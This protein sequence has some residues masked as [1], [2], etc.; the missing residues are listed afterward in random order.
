MPYLVMRGDRGQVYPLS[1]TLVRIGRG[2]DQDIILPHDQSSISRRHAELIHRDGRW[3]LRDLGSRNGTQLAG[4]K[5]EPDVPLPLNDGDIINMGRLEL[6]FVL[7]DGQL[8]GQE[9]EDALVV[10]SLTATLLADQTRRISDVRLLS[11]SDQRLALLMRLG[12]AVG[13][14]PAIPALLKHLLKLV[15]SSLGPERAYIG[16]YDQELNQWKHEVSYVDRGKRQAPF[17]R[18]SK[19]MEW[20][21]SKGQA[22]VTGDAQQENGDALRSPTVVRSRVRSAMCSPLLDQ[23]T[24]IGVLY[25][26]DRERL[27][28]YEEE[29]LRFVTFLG[30]FAGAVIASAIRQDLNQRKMLALEQGRSSLVFGNSPA[31]QKVKEQVL[32]VAPTQLAV[33]LLGETGT[34]K[35]LLARE[36]HRRSPPPVT[37]IPFPFP[38]PNWQ[39]PARTHRLPSPSAESPESPD[40]SRPGTPAPSLFPDPSGCRHI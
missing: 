9:E 33:L 26:D 38:R 36:I 8:P 4:K 28:A 18:G 5:V 13:Q 10:K 2:L 37:R 6:R 21:L 11:P 23:S 30:I 3:H 24:P 15:F 7:T 39:L 19:L 34:G 1:G 35:T 27:Y 16:I 25:L 40:G 14:G 29:D 17:A 20:V 12:E 31:M 32:G 22:Y